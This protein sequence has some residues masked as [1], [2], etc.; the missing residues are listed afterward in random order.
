MRNVCVALLALDIEHGDNDYVW[1][2]FCRLGVWVSNQRTQYKNFIKG[3]R[4]SL[5]Q[6]RIDIL[7]DIGFIWDVL[8][9][10]F[11]LRLSQLV[12]YKEAN[13]DCNV[14]KRYKDNPE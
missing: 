3:K 1:Y 2:I 12:E 11:D 10:T 8:Q 14:P 13:G 6:V 7:N 4:S 5:T 9:D